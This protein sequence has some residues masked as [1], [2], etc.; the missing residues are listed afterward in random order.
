MRSALAL[1]ALMA[2]SLAPHAA[3]AATQ[4]AVTGTESG[5]PEGKV[6]CLLTA[7]RE[8]A[9][10]EQVLVSFS[11]QGQMPHNL[12]ARVGSAD[13]CVPPGAATDPGQVMEPGAFG[14]FGFTAPAT[15]SV[16]YWCAV[17]GHEQQGMSGTWTIQGSPAPGPKGSPSAG[18][19]SIALG[20]GLLALAL[21]RRGR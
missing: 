14:G 8:L 19:V 1:A 12:C 9:P 5:C 18:L 6:F 4:V 7:T 13:T 21:R 20:T 11:N 10:G 17:P 3:A 2:L 16:K 15:G